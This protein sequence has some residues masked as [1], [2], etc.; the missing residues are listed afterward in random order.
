MTFRLSNTNMQVPSSSTAFTK[1]ILHITQCNSV[2][3]GAEIRSAENMPHCLQ[4]LMWLSSISRY[5]AVTR[6]HISADWHTSLSTVDMFSLFVIWSLLYILATSLCF[7]HHHCIADSSVCCR[8]F[9]DSSANHCHTWVSCVTAV[10]L[11]GYQAETTVSSL[12]SMLTLSHTHTDINTLAP[13]RH[14]RE[15]TVVLLSIYLSVCLSV[16]PSIHPSI[17]PFVRLSDH[18]SIHTSVPVHSKFMLLV[19]F[20]CHM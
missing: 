12:L 17:R 6:S 9:W 1:H 18:P 20:L 4:L 3:S 14:Q 11:F 16:Y 7:W 19:S 13:P 5:R 15:V 8:Y 10:E 2:G